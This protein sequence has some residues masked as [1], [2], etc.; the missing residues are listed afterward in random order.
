MN[1]AGIT[2]TVSGFFT[3]A[4]ADPNG[5]DYINWHGRDSLTW[6]HGRH[7]FKGGYEVYKVDFT[8]NSAFT[9]TRSVTFSG[10][11]TGNAL[12]DFTLGVFDSMNVVFGQPGSNPVQWKQFFYVQDEFGE[13]IKWTLEGSLPLK[14]V[15]ARK[16]KT[17]RM[18]I[19][20]MI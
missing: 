14:K 17:P 2:T 15:L 11:A 16:I 10:A 19:P 8:L 6:V 3:L 12:A 9:N 7:T 5:Q 1:N 20:N 13:Y 18:I 4:P